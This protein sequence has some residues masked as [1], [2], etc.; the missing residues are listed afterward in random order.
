MP[1]FDGYVAVDWSARN[2]PKYNED[3][4][5]IAVCDLH[6]PPTLE[7]LGTRREAVDRVEALLGEGTSTRHRL[8][9]GFDFAFGYPEGTARMLTGEYGW[10]AVW[11]R[12]AQVI[13]D[14]PNNCNNRFEA[15]AELNEVFEGEGPFYG[16]HHTWHIE[17]LLATRPQHGWGGNL[18]PER[19]YAEEIVRKGQTV[20]KLYGRGSVGSQTLTGTPALQRIRRRT[21]SQ[22]W[23]FETLGDGQS[24]VLAEIYPSLINPLPPLPAW[25]TGVSDARQVYAVALTLRELD[26]V[27]ELQQHL[28]AP[29]Q[30]RHL[31]RR[32]EGAILGMQDRV[33]FNAAAAR[34]LG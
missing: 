18:P 22:I 19:R 15:A 9:C 7:N 34:A 8:L 20:W 31:V 32:E 26:Q 6:R 24:H 11:A 10:A 2:E 1:L 4:I 5:W 25:V 13:E 3:S 33:G 29:H 21:G 23:P 30:I 28:H 12:V 16:R 17:G 27:D 14:G